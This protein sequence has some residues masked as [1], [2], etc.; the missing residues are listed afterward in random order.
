MGG[1]TVTKSPLLLIIV[2]LVRLPEKGSI[3]MPDCYLCVTQLPIAAG[4]IETMS[5]S[6]RPD[7]GKC[8]RLSL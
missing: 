8:E 3:S 5:V 2:A 1:R 6:D 4:I 7:A